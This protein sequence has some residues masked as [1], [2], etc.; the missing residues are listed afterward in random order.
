MYK[1]TDGDEITATRLN[2]SGVRFG[3]TGADGA[4]S[5]TSGTTTL[6]LGGA[7][8]FVKNYTT[9]DI[10]G[11]G[12]LAFNNPASRG[13]IIIL[14]ATGNVT[15][16]SSADPAIDLRDIGGTAGGAGGVAGAG[17]LNSGGMQS[18]GIAGTNDFNGYGGSGGGNLNN[19][20]AGGSYSDAQSGVIG[21][22]A[23]INGSQMLPK[24]VSKTAFKIYPGGGG[25]GGLK[26]GASPGAS[27]AGGRG[28]GALVIECGGALNFDAIINGVG[29][30]GSGSATEGTRWGGGGGAGGSVLMLYNTLA[31]NTGTITLTGGAGGPSG[32]GGY[33]GAAGGAGSI[34]QSLVEAFYD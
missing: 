29:A 22:K 1:W 30:D 14:K 20:T 10:T 8:I 33:P 12:K 32:T 25:S 34:G 18:F 19:G 23:R 13:T 11:T 3:G 9:I 21:W 6:D 26:C 24:L 31:A 4:L 28:A 5:V 2:Q 27:Y 16:T 7:N 17:W 15:I